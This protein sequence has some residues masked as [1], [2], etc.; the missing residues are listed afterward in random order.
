L[1]ARYR[2]D[3]ESRI[4]KLAKQQSESDKEKKERVAMEKKDEKKARNKKMREDWR[5]NKLEGTRSDTDFIKEIQ[6]IGIGEAIR[7]PKQKAIEAMRAGP[8]MYPDHI[9]P[10]TR[11]INYE[12]VDKASYDAMLALGATVSDQL[13]GR[14]VEEAVWDEDTKP[15]SE[16]RYFGGVQDDQ[17]KNYRELKRQERLQQTMKDFSSRAADLVSKRNELIAQGYVQGGGGRA[18]EASVKMCCASE[19][20]AKGCCARAK[21]R[22]QRGVARARKGAT[23]LSRDKLFVLHPNIPRATH[24][25]RS[26]QRDFLMRPLTRTCVA[27]AGTRCPG[28][29]SG[30]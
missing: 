10:K 8:A 26:R 17:L 21:Q 16:N 27:R 25:R 23:A 30:P 29:R 18:S 14:I 22:A 19:A 9:G 28:R 6:K 20:R 5:T 7:N 1:F 3:A 24:L 4:N 2:R 11:V 13:E 12:E 15:M